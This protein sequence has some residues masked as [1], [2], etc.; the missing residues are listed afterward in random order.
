M[1]EGTKNIVE[2][3]KARGIRKVVGCMSGTTR[4]HPICVRFRMFP[5]DLCSFSSRGS[6]FLLWDRSK[7]PPRL[8]AVTEDHDRMYDVLKS[9]SLDYVAVMP[10]HIGSEC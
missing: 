9:S 3:M 8:L 5:N 7:V 1:S 10:P 2:A 4:L 6:A